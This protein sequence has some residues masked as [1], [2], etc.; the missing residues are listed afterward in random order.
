MGCCGGSRNRT[1]IRFGP[2]KRAPISW[3]ELSNRRTNTGTRRPSGSSFLFTPAGKAVAGGHSTG[4][5]GPI[6]EAARID[7]IQNWIIDTYGREVRSARPSPPRCP[8]GLVELGFHDGPRNYSEYAHLRVCVDSDRTILRQH[9]YNADHV[10]FG[11]DEY[12]LN[13]TAHG[14]YEYFSAIRLCRLVL[15]RR[16]FGARPGVDDTRRRRR[17]GLCS[18]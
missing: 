12:C 7:A 11:A 18:R 17:S 4:V 10:V 8:L 14:E 3:N 5:L 16:P 6:S 9:R 2:S 1:Q 15:V 13:Y